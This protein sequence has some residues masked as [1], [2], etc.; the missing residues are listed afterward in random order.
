MPS[1][2]LIVFAP[3]DHADKV[4]QAIAEAGGGK[5]GKYTF[6][7]FSTKGIGRFEPDPTANP[8][9]GKPGKLEAVEEEHIEVTLR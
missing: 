2:K 5:L 1:Y 3:L 4:C 7:N 6:C 8:H 9:I